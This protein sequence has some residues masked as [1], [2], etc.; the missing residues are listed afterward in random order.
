MTFID[1]NKLLRFTIYDI[2]NNN[3]M[4]TGALFNSYCMIN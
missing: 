2:I 1:T 3:S 4:K